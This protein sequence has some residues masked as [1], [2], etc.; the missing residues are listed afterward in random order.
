MSAHD[1]HTPGNAV[2]PL[3]D[4]ELG[5]LLDDLY[6]FDEGIDLICDGIR[7]IALR[8]LPADRV[9]LLLATIA[10]SPD[11]T[12]VVGAFGR[13]VERIADADNTPALRDL[14]LDAQ[15]RAQR[16]GELT[17]HALTDP[18]LRAPASNACAALDTPPTWRCQ[19]C[20]T[21]NT[22]TDHACHTCGTTPTRKD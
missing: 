13:L 12:D 21:Y 4:T 9:Q 17:A 11:A 3:T 10:G 8:R 20:D 18:D 6:G 16:Q 1:V 22:H 15:K 14:P 2:P 19:D 5:G 7:N